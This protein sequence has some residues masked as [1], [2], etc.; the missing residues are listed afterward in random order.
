MAGPKFRGGYVI[1]ADRWNRPLRLHR[2]TWTLK[3][4]HQERWFLVHNYEKLEET[5]KDPD[6]VVESKRGGSGCLYYKHFREFKLND[7]GSRSLATSRFWVCIVADPSK[8]RLLTFYPSEAI[9][10]GR[11]LYDKAKGIDLI[12]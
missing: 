12:R 4:A 10:E 9:K 11:L 7:S 2:S 1:L 8:R 5:L 3:L 6:Q